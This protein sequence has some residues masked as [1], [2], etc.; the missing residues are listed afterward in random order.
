MIYQPRNA[1]PSGN[2]ID[3]SLNNSF[4]M[5]IQTNSY[6]TD[7]QLY[8]YNFYN[9][10]VYSGDKVTLETPCYNGDILTI[11][12]DATTFNLNNGGDYKWR[13]RLYQPESDILIT[14]GFIQ[15][16]N[17][18]NQLYLQPNANIQQGMY[19]SMYDQV[20]YITSYDNET[21]LATL[22]GG[23]TS[24]PTKGEQY[25]IYSDYIETVP[26]YIFYAR[27]TPNVSISNIPSSALTSK[28]YAFEGFYHQRNEIPITYHQFDLYAQGDNGSKNL[29]DST[30]RVYSA[31]LSYSYDAFRTG[32]T[33]FIQMTVENTMGIRATTEMYSF[34]VNYDIVEYIQQ[35]QAIFD[36]QKN[37]VKVSW[38][39]P[40]ENDATS[41]TGSFDFLY[42]TPYQGSSSLYT[43]GYT[44][45][46]N[47]QEG[48]C[49]LPENFNITFQ[50]N[51]DGNFFYGDDGVYNEAV[52]L[53]S[54]ST[55]DSSGNGNFEIIIDKNTLKFNMAPDISL[56]APFY[57][58]TTQSFVLT[59]DGVKQS[60]IDYVWIDDEDW[61]DNFYW[62]E[63]GTS[64]ERV[65]NHWWKVQITNSGLIVKEVYTTN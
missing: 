34:T 57:T 38:V 29:V 14:Y 22:G 52:T 54:A 4:S 36:S 21:G 58:N 39:T 23:F 6:I 3:V 11:P 45:S 49:V 15:Q 51:P 5:E 19:V 55:D 30:G 32:N 2:C 27:E 9:K 62:T 46:W 31:N 64:L 28:S 33:Y 10:S 65:C 20:R 13:I 8:I 50:F 7:Y 44:A 53:I 1:Y 16:T 63:G 17:T 35:P 61:N 56:T 47:N 37:A 24:T 25:Y 26:D 48:L 18:A 42:N 59:S 41:S 60:S 12:I 40:I 43:N